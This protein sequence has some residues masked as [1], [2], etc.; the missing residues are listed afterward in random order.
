MTKLFASPPALRP[1]RKMSAQPV[2]AVLT[3]AALLE[4]EIRIERAWV[5]GTE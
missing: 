1:L 2:L 4:M 3:L 5:N